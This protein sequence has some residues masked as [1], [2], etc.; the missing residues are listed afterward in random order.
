MNQQP[1]YKRQFNNPMQ[2]VHLPP[3]GYND[4]TQSVYLPARGYDDPTQSIYLPPGGY[5]P[6]QQGYASQ[7]PS[8]VDF[9]SRSSPPEQHWRL[10]NLQKKLLLVLSIALVTSIVLALVSYQVFPLASIQATGMNEIHRVPAAVT[11][12]ATPAPPP[13]AVLNPSSV[14]G[15]TSGPP[16]KYPGISWTRISYKT[17]GGDYFGARL[18]ST[19]QLYHNQGGHVLILLCQHPGQHLLNMV[20]FNDVAQAGAD[21]VACGNEEMKH[22]TYP[23]YLSPQDFARFFDLCERTVHAA[24][25]G[26]SVLLGSLDP[27]VGGVDHQPLLQ[28]VSYLNAV[29]TAM[30]TQVR[31]GGNWSWRAQA[32]GLIDSW[33]NGFPSKNV[34]SLQ[35][36]FVFWA[37]QFQ[38]DL[39]SGELGQHIWVVEGTGCVNGCGLKTHHQISVAHIM[40]L[41]TDVQTAMQYKVPFF[42][43]SGKD[44][45]Q[46]G[47]FW[48]MGVLDRHGHAKPLVQDLALGAK[49]LDLSC[50]S[51]SVL[52][53]EQEQLLAKLYSGCTLPGN[54]ASLLTST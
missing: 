23:T 2:P 44:F 43:F 53:T 47:A 14:L 34:N 26:L 4:S 15:I 46:A 39:N 10:N 18:K 38:V 22:N 51:G 40:T 33:H 27:H 3:G 8:R 5:H 50:P 24:R 7:Y 32:M 48:P 54:W 42:Y 12:S 49:S 6:M 52:V 1:P 25:P 9:A 30:N 19:V 45:F 28:Q 35:A 11:P 36:L 21:A 16:S 17:C 13:L 37:Q 31:P 20:W 29:Q 41:I